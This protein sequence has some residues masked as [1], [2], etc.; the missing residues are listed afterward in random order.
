MRTFLPSG[1]AELDRLAEV[2]R[3]LNPE[4][5]WEVTIQRY[6]GRRSASQ[7]KLFHALIDAIASETGNDREDLKDWLKGKFGPRVALV[8]DGREEIVPKLSRR[9]T[10][11]EMSEM[12]DRISAWA[13]AELGISI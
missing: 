10:P 9:Y 4:K 13:G 3:S 5:P 7:N 2:I 11:E 8:I 6:S 1:K 12:V